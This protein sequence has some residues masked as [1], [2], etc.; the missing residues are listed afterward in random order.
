MPT[1]G[2]TPTQRGNPPPPDNDAFSDDAPTAFDPGEGKW[3]DSATDPSATDPSATDPSATDPL[4]DDASS[5]TVLGVP[6]A[7]TAIAAPP[8]SA[9]PG[10]TQRAQSD[11]PLES[12]PVERPVDSSLMKAMEDRPRRQAKQQAPVDTSMTKATP[13]QRKRQRPQSEPPIDSSLM[14]TRPEGPQRQRRSEPSHAKTTVDDPMQAKTLPFDRS[15]KKPSA[16]PLLATTTPYSRAM[17]QAAK[18]SALAPE[19]KPADPPP[20]I[21]AISMMTPVD[22]N[23]RAAPKPEREPP[24]VQLRAMADKSR[25]QQQNLGN[26]APP[27]DPAEA[28]ARTVRDYAL[29]GSLAVALAAV[30]ALVVWLVGT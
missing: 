14:K 23:A 15:A 22:P 29:W 19:P 21:R 24:H 26:L 25:A 2:K 7:P 1:R 12:P 4:A 3:L 13:D 9:A 18:A 8:V 10:R 28:R 20:V 16:D 27:Y 17:K 30:I 6:S 11:R 5:R